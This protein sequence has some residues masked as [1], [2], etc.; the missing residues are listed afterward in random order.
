[1]KSPHPEVPARASR[2]ASHVPLRDPVIWAWLVVALLAILPAAAALTHL[3]DHAAAPA[4][5]PVTATAA[6]PAAAA[7]NGGPVPRAL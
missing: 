4:T 2:G 5:A 1:M 6:A 3:R 7:S